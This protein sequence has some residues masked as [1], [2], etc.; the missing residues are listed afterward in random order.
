MAIQKKHQFK[1]S[2]TAICVILRHK[3]LS[4]Q[5]WTALVL[6]E[7]ASQLDSTNQEIGYILLLYH[8][9][10]TFRRLRKHYLQAIGKMTWRCVCVHKQLNRGC[11]RSVVQHRRDIFSVICS[12][13]RSLLCLCE[14]NAVLQGKIAFESCNS[15][16]VG[17]SKYFL[18]GGGGGRAVREKNAPAAATCVRLPRAPTHQTAQHHNT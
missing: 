11:G 1:F 3:N 8:F 13:S 5:I 16:F 4:N 9:R 18:F 10:F 6:V 7:R 17:K 2:C 15:V 14:R 12:S